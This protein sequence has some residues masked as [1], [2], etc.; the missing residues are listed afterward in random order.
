[1]VLR[2]ISILFLLA[3]SAFSSAQVDTITTQE[4]AELHI[5]HS[6]KKAALYSAIL[7]GAGQIYNRS[8]VKPPVIYAGFVAL[9]YGFV[10]YQKRYKE[11]QR[12]YDDYRMPYLQK[13]EVPPADVQLSVFGEA[14]YFPENVREGRDYYRRWRDM[15]LIGA[16]AWYALTIIEAYVHAYFYHFDISDKLSVSLVPYID[17]SHTQPYKGFHFTLQF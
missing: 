15:M 4:S 8:Y 16:G 2:I 11:F 5:Q 3:C 13:G 6:P 12:V 10:H 9:G 7:P 17:L 14:A 1:M